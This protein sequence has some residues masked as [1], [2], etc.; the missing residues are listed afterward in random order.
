[1]Q[2][3]NEFNVFETAETL[4]NKRENVAYNVRVEQGNFSVKFA[5]EDSTKATKL[6]RMLEEVVSVNIEQCIIRREG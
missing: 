6:C 2:V 1:M 3:G 4:S 5:C